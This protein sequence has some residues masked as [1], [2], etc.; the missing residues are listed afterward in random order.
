MLWLEFH[1]Q[2]HY[3]VGAS[4]KGATPRPEGVV[5]AAGETGKLGTQDSLKA[6]CRAGRVNQ[7]L[8]L[9]DQSSY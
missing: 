9:C 6:L 1:K 4:G 5:A 3:T 2:N 8:L 7:S